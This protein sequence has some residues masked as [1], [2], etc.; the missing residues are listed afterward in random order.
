MLVGV[1][2][3]VS[4]VCPGT[5]EQSTVYIPL[6]I[7][8]FFHRRN[9]RLL[10]IV[11]DSINGRKTLERRAADRLLKAVAQQ[12]QG[13]LGQLVVV[14]AQRVSGGLFSL[15]GGSSGTLTPAEQEVCVCES[16]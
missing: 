9:A 14:N 10:L 7:V 13:S 6:Y 3:N 5:T 4:R 12:E 15:S 2:E 8:S 11:G 16:M 1:W